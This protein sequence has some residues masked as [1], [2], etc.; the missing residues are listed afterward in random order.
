MLLSFFFLL[1]SLLVDVM[2]LT[3]VSFL[4][5]RSSR[6]YGVSGSGGLESQMIYFHF[7]NLPSFLVYYSH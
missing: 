3:S 5:F 6:C 1:S 7:L 2:H 4:V